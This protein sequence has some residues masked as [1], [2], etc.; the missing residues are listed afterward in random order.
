MRAAHAA[1]VLLLLVSCRTAAPRVESE[2]ARILRVEENLLPAVVLEGRA[3][4]RPIRERMERLHV[5]QV[6]VA[7]LDDGRLV[8]AR[9]YGGAGPETLFQAASLSKPVAAVV[10]LRLVAAGKLALDEDV[11]RR[12]RSWRLPDGGEVTLRQLLSH[13][14]GLSIM[15]FPGYPAGAPLPT[16]P[17]ILDGAPPANTQAVRVVGPRGTFRYSGG[18]YTLV[19]LLVEDVTGRRFADVARDELLEPLGLTSS[20]FA[21]PL[22]E[23][24][25]ARAAAGHG[26]DGAEV[27]G[28]WHVYPEQAA[29]GLWTTPSELARFLAEVGRARAGQSTML[30]KELAVAATTS[31]A[32]NY[33]LGFA[34]D[35]AGPTLRIRH[36]GANRGYRASFVYY[37]E[38]GRGAVVMT[39]GDAG[40]TL[41]AELMRALAVEYA[42]PGFPGPVVK[43]EVAADP[44]RY[45]DYAGRYRLDAGMFVTVAVDGAR[46]TIT[47]PGGEAA[48]LHP[49]GDDRF[50]LL[51]S[52]ATVRFVREGDAVTALEAVIEGR[53]IV[54]PRE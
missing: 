25:A 44:S 7:V 29:A 49:A 50:F 42:W 6:G 31:G 48:E 4:G 26:A 41:A 28:R 12:L 39:S 47:T 16:L 35:G 23:A 37:L 53:T 43:K 32:G 18:G 20:T 3:A 11:G 40:D 46:L 45:P 9:G 1:A 2:E 17:Q 24:L 30:P 33:G 21:Q 8:W 14:G 51:E 15:G 52:N 38:S 34:V 22:P 13:T 19:Q 54:A 36:S 27:P 5:P 10:A